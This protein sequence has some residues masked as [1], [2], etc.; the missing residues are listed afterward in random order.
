MPTPAATKITISSACPKCGAMKKSGKLSCCARGGSWFGNCGST[1]NAKAGH[2][3]YEGMQ[4]C[5]KGQF[6]AADQQ[7]HAFQRKDN[8]S[9]YDAGVRMQSKTVLVA[10]HMFASLQTNTSTPVSEI[11]PI[12]VSVGTPSRAFVV[13][14]TGT[15]TYKTTSGASTTITHTIVNM[16]TPKSIIPGVTGSI[17]SISTDSVDMPATT[18]PTPSHPSVS[19]SEKLL[20]VVAL[21]SIIL[22][23]VCYY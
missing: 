11:V 3:W 16:P 2:T 6:Q 22:I 19:A 17:K 4:A 5:D 1:G 14:D 15:T 18:P 8:L 10:A 21:V 23:A 9:S 20:H 13:Y 7:R 12:T